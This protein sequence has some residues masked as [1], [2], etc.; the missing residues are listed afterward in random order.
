MH[1]VQV[2]VLRDELT[3]M[4]I[5]VAAWEVPVLE[6]KH[7]DE[8]LTVGETVEFENRAWPTDARSEM[9]RLGQLYGRTGSG[10]NAPTFAESVYGGGTPG[11]KKLQ[12]AMD[13][14]RKAHETKKG[15]AAS[16]AAAALVG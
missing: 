15:K 11:I 3:T 4:P 14:A 2:T 16:S 8:R 1:Y 10:D 7:S 9:Q 13:A 12:S 6:A 5:H